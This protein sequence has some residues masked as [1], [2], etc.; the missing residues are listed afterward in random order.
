MKTQFESTFFPYQFY[1]GRLIHFSG[2]LAEIASFFFEL[3][4][5]KKKQQTNKTKQSKKQRKTLAFHRKCRFRYKFS[6]MISCLFEGGSGSV[7]K[8]KM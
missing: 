5:F 7:T 6:Q 3:S 8:D 1:M 4:S 2:L